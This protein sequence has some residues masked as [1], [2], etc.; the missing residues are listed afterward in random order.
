M[1]EGHQRR[2]RL[3]WAQ[4]WAGSHC[5]WPENRHTTSRTDGKPGQIPKSPTTDCSTLT[6]LPH[7]GYD[8][9]CR[10]PGAA[11]EGKACGTERWRPSQTPPWPGSQ[12]FRLILGVPWPNR[13]W[14]V[15]AT[16]PAWG[17][18]NQ[19]GHFGEGQECP[20]RSGGGSSPLAHFSSCDWW[21]Q[22]SSLSTWGYACLAPPQLKSQK[23]WEAKGKAWKGER[24]SNRRAGTSP[25]T[26]G[27]KKPTP[28]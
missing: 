19:E 16:S 14:W 20:D 27:A 7:S 13:Q 6:L 26:S 23:N 21:W 15:D 10:W 2:A 24:R 22:R 17:P 4:G 18:G 3:H 28:A 5:S 11:P 12:N 9:R 8:G 1:G 25:V